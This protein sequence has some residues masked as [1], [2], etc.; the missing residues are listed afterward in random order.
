MTTEYKK[1]PTTFFLCVTSQERKSFLKLKPLRLK[2][3]Q[4][5]TNTIKPNRNVKNRIYHAVY[6]IKATVD[7][8]AITKTFRVFSSLLVDNALI[9]K[10]VNKGTK[11]N[12]VNCVCPIWMANALEKSLAEYFKS[13]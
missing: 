5:V 11:L 10:I 4:L 6:A 3:I 7:K 9:K 1:Q 8:V 12:A 13:P 2:I